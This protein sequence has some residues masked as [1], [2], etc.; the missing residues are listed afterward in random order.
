MGEAL[1]LSLLEPTFGRVLKIWWQFAWRVFLY[2]SVIYFAAILVAVP[3]QIPW[4]DWYL[5]AT[6]AHIIGLFVVGIVV[7][8]SLL[9]KKF[10]G[11]RMCVVAP[12]ETP[13]TAVPSSSE[14]AP[15]FSHALRVWW[16]LLWRTLAWV[17]A[18]EYLIVIAVMV[19]VLVAGARSPS[20]AVIIG[21]NIGYTV[22]GYFF[23]FGLLPVLALVSFYV[24]KR[25]LRKD[26]RTFR[27]AI[28][29]RTPEPLPI[30]PPPPELPS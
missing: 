28:V 1:N 6:L 4:S 11:F 24:L 18:I 22:G 3:F 7:M 19:P 23:T 25:L 14:L 12:P 21:Y 5:V 10:R 26:F 9:Q 13:P 15:T 8:K 20:D 30:P 2:S 17:L 16:A 27:I 29:S